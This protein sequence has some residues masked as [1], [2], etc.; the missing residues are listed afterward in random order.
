MKYKVIKA[1]IDKLTGS[2]MAP[3]SVVEYGKERADE[4]KEQGYIEPVTKRAPVKLSE[5]TLNKLP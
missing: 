4:L 3:D 1:Y 2:Y 5:E